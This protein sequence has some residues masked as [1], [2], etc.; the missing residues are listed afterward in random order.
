MESFS[1]QGLFQQVKQGFEETAQGEGAAAYSKLATT[2]ADLSTAVREHIQTKTSGD[3]KTIIGKLQAGQALSSEELSIAKLWIVGA[4]D[5]Y[6]K[7]ENN[8]QDWIGELKRIGGEINRLDAAKLEITQAFY[9]QALLMD[10][11]RVAW[12]MH[13]YLE[14]KARLSLFAESTKELDAEESK[15]LADILSRKLASPD[16]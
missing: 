14:Q 6:T 8:V 9:V 11:I 7:H 5:A 10:A 4:A 12:D 15:I 13:H 16:M 2:M 3:V 1:M